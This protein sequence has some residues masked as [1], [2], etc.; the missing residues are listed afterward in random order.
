MFS[1]GND[2]PVNSIYNSFLINQC[3]LQFLERWRQALEQF[4]KR[5]DCETG[6]FRTIP[7]MVNALMGLWRESSRKR[8]PS[9]ITICFP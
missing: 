8:T 4:S 6:V 7:P 9:D 5:F 3:L 2:R 1:G